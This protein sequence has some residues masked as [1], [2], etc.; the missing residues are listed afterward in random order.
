[1]TDPTG[2]NDGRT[3]QEVLDYL[4]THLNGALRRP[5]MYG[6]E[7]AIRLYLGAVAFADASEQA[8]QQELK[9]LQTR[10]G[11]SSTGVSGVLQDL[12]GDAHEG[13]VASVYA[14]IA[15]RQG[16]LRPDRTLTSAEYHEICRGCE[17]WC[18]KDRLLSDVVTAFGPPSVLFGGNNPNYPKTLAYATDQRDDTLLCFHLWNSF[19]A[20]PSSSSASVHAEPVLWAFRH[21]GT[22]FT[23][24]FTFTPEGSA[25]RLPGANRTEPEISRGKSARSE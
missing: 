2:R 4:V 6:G 24:G 20:D 15:H 13:A 12:W 9:D 11:F 22:L 21:G 8:W 17:T 16:W 1:M 19:A 7:T 18:R 3:A 25:H 10:R 14:E 5:G 23:D